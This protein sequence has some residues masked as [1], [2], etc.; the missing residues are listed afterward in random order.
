VP[1]LVAPVRARAAAPGEHL[2]GHQH[3]LVHRR[4][5]AGPC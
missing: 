2:H 3:G 1:H 5:A 4:P